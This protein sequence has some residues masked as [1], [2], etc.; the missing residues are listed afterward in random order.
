MAGRLED[1]RAVL[2]QH[3]FIAFGDGEVQRRQAGG[4]FSGADDPRPRIALF[5]VADC[6]DVVEMVMGQPDVGECPA[7][8]LQ[9]G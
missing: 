5:E 1:L 7:F 2:A 8:F 3:Q 6:P 4:V 9:G